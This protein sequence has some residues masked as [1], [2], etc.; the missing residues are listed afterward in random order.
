LLRSLN[1]RRSALVSPDCNP[2][3][4][5]EGKFLLYVPEENVSD[6]ASELF[7]LGFFDENDAPPWD[8]WVAFSKNTLLSWVPSELVHLVQHGIDVNAVDCIH[9][10]T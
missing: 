9:W 1:V 7:S 8:T 6:G 3:I 5:L 4:A 10:M 2:D